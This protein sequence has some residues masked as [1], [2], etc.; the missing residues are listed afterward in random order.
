ML[1]RL[2]ELRSLLGRLLREAE[3]DT[4]KSWVFQV[5][6]ECIVAAREG[7]ID[8]DDIVKLIMIMGRIPSLDVI[9]DGVFLL[10]DL[11]VFIKSSTFGNLSR[12]MESCILISNR[13]SKKPIMV[14]LVTGR[15]VDG[16][17]RYRKTEVKLRAGDL[18]V[19]ST[20]H[21]EDAVWAF[22]PET[23]ELLYVP[24]YS[25]ARSSEKKG[26][27]CAALSVIEGGDV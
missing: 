5:I 25:Q 26:K 6:E 24:S 14:P 4:P 10:S 2:E 12:V 1:L 8:A 17:L 3:G 23:L 13:V 20:A 16:T 9:P 15:N 11:R 7:E 18:K 27:P 21:T 22:D 19:V